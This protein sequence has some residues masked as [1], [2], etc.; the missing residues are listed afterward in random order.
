MLRRTVATQL[1]RAVH[2]GGSVLLEG[3]RSAGKTT[4]V[5]AEFPRMLYVSMEDAKDRS[6]ARRDPALFAARLRGPA[7]VDDVHL[8]PEL[9]RHLAGLSRQSAI[10]LTSSRK[11]SFPVPT[12]RLYRPTL[13]EL[14]GRQAV[15]MDMLGH[16]VPAQAGK[17]RQVAPP[18]ADYSSI[19]RDV[20]DL[21][22]F[23]DFDEFCR[24][25]E[26]ASKASCRIL[27]AQRLARLAGI[28]RSTAVRW[29]AILDSCFLTIRIEPS[30]LDFGRRIVRS[31]K[32][33]F[34]DSD[35]FESRVVSELYRNAVHAGTPADLRFWR[36][37]NGL[38][39]A[40]VYQ[41]PGSPPM[42]I[43]IVETPSALDFARLLRWMN[44]AGA[45]SA[46]II[47]A[48]APDPQRGPILRYGLDSL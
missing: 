44:L 3:P 33:H 29:L 2:T 16:F 8:A 9:A 14:A 6:F 19:E 46:A 10:I 40:L 35:V 41:P 25:V 7:I 21:V 24:F 43:H 39:V 5:R 27:D 13:A 37:S 23:R 42:G 45:R 30:D 47:S 31:P 28:S 18:A 11:L 12:V 17:T 32:L 22:Q 1:R 38:E 4:L 36:D 20:R 34:L 15:S 26:I 48:Q